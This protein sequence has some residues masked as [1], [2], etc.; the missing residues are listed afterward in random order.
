MKSVEGFKGVT[1]KGMKCEMGEARHSR[2]SGPAGHPPPPLGDTTPVYLP[3]VDSG[4]PSYIPREDSGTPPSLP[5]PTQLPLGAPAG[6]A[7]AGGGLE[8]GSL[9]FLPGRIMIKRNGTIVL[10]GEDGDAPGETVLFPCSDRL[11]RPFKLS[12]PPAP[13]PMLLRPPAVTASSAMVAGTWTRGMY[14]AGNPSLPPRR[15]RGE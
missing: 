15:E 3:R 8:A 12:I 1:G 13:A 2:A 10:P 11:L 7:A 14:A 6:D 5:P 4:T 9:F